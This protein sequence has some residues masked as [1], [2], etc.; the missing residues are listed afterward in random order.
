M[1]EMM[2]LHGA[3]AVV[4]AMVHAIHA[5]AAVALPT[6]N[7]AWRTKEPDYPLLLLLRLQLLVVVE[8][9]IS[10][11]LCLW[12]SAMYAGSLCRATH[13][14]CPRWSV[15]REEL[16]KKRYSSADAVL[17]AFQC[18]SL[19]PVVMPVPCCCDQ[20]LAVP[21]STHRAVP[22]VA[23]HHADCWVLYLHRVALFCIRST[24]R[25]LQ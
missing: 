20:H 13:T 4:L 23:A 5:K 9:I 18:S 12:Q 19:F 17:V 8:F 3:M 22:H 24:C 7:Q 21:V 15:A 10:G 16:A 11:S 6:A 14:R 2:K 25:Q 1:F